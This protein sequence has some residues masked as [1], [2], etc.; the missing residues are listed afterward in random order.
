MATEDFFS[1]TNFWLRGSVLHL[2]EVGESSLDV[3]DA[4]FFSC[5]NSIG[6]EKKFSSDGNILA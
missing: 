5:L 4:K 3:H 2:L 1:D 6:V